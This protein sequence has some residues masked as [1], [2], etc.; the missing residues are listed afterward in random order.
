ME[1]REHIAENL[2]MAAV[3]LEA[4]KKKV[5]KFYPDDKENIEALAWLQ[6]KVAEMQFEMMEDK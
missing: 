6:I 5:K 3:Q 4:A 1:M 2:R